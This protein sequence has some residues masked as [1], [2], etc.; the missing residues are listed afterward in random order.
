MGGGGGG[1]FGPRSD[2]EKL[3]QKLRD[4][5]ARTTDA[6]YEAKVAELLAS[7]LTK[8]NNR[9]NEA[10]NRHIE[11]I[12]KALQ[13]ELEGTVDLLF[14]GSVA[15]QTY[16]DGFSDI[17]SLVILDN[18]ELADQSPKAAKEYFAQRIR[19]RFPKSQVEI[20][21]LA[22]TVRFSDAEIQLL[23]AI[24][25]KNHIKIADKTGRAWSLISPKEFSSAFTR[26][27]QQVGRKV[28]P[29]IKLA[30]AIISNLPEKHQISGYHAESLAIDIFKNYKEGLKPKVMLKHFFQA[31]CQRVRKPIIDRTGQSV[32][33]DDYLGPANSLERR[34]VSDAFD[35]VYRRL[36]NADNAS[37]LD[38]WN[39]LFGI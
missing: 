32:H 33:V 10:I 37:S 21:K 28:V 34:I 18:C 13:K 31:A 7:L 20:G 24:S 11:E 23:P 6:A 36:N 16:I 19:E 30:K 15:K 17:D 38:E 25:C 29:V 12:R 26:I 1:Y 9:N 39:K 27:N 3:K 8:Y 22:V 14:G 5:E 4:S 35:R 2:P